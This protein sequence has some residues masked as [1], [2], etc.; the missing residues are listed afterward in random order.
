MAIRSVSRATKAQSPKIQPREIPNDLLTRM[1]ESI[2]VLEVFR[3]SLD[4]DHAPEQMALQVVI[5]ELHAVHDGLDGL[6]MPT[7]AERLRIIKA[8]PASTWMSPATRKQL[9]AEARADVAAERSLQ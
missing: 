7:P 8:Q 1:L 9:I 4:D 5:R 6:R 2:S 3:R